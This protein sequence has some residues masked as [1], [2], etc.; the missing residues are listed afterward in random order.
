MSS[1]DMPVAVIVIVGGPVG[2]VGVV[3]AGVVATGG[4]GAVGVDDVD[5]PEQAEID[6]T[7]RSRKMRSTALFSP[8]AQPD[9]EAYHTRGISP[10]EA[11]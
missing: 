5:P 1:G 4:V 2:V 10:A 11:S 7:V 9:S 3:G 6:K 8:A